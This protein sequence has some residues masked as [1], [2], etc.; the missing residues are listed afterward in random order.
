M[1]IACVILHIFNFFL[2]K[3]SFANSPTKTKQTNKEKKHP[4]QEHPW[5]FH[6]CLTL[7]TS[8]S[9]NRSSSMLFQLP[10]GTFITFSTVPLSGITVRVHQLPFPSSYRRNKVGIKNQPFTC[11]NKHNI[12]LSVSSAYSVHSDLHEAV[13]HICADEDRPPGHGVDGIVHE[14]VVACKLNHIVW[15]TLSGLEAAKCLTGTLMEAEKN[16]IIYIFADAM[17]L[18]HYHNMGAA[19]LTFH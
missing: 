17:C 10:L 6:N 19:I 13:V 14:R 8:S 15:E 1:H 4:A 9:S 12:V 18:N 3:L 2:Y 5:N 11:S 7:K 16:K